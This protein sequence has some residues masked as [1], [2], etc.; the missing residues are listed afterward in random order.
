MGM[1]TAASPG[2]CAWSSSPSVAVPNAV[3]RP[4]NGWINVRRSG[5]DHHHLRIS[6]DGLRG[7]RYSDGMIARADGGHAAAMLLL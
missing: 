7:K 6:T 2:T 5:G 3:V 1:M 4:S